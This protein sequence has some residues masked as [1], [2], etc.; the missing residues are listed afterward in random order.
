MHSTVCTV[1]DLHWSRLPLCTFIFKHCYSLFVTE[2]YTI[3]IVV[4]QSE[5]FFLTTS[6]RLNYFLYKKILFDIVD[7]VNPTERRVITC[8]HPYPCMHVLA[9]RLCTKHV[10]V[11][12]HIYYCMYHLDPRA[13]CQT[14]LVL[15]IVGVTIS[16]FSACVNTIKARVT[17][18]SQTLSVAFIVALWKFDFDWH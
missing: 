18:R 11:Y 1:I 3:Y 12:G 13:L 5:Y 9:C 4:F 6:F 7:S 16:T 17:L 14:P 10:H 8:H 2:Y 15:T